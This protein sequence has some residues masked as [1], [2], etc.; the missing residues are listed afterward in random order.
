MLNT[1]QLSLR[2]SHDILINFEVQY[3]IL[4]NFSLTSVFDKIYVCE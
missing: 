2:I 4:A 1:Q 3:K